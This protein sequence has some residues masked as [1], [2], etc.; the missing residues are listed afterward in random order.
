MN[1]KKAQ[2]YLFSGSG[3]TFVIAKTICDTLKQN[4][5]STILKPIP[6]EDFNLDDD[7]LLGIAFPTAWFSTYPFVL[8]FIDK[9][10]Q[11]NNREVILISTMTQTHFGMPQAIRKILVKKGYKPIGCCT[12]RMPSNYDI[13]NNHDARKNQLI[14][15]KSICIAENFAKDLIKGKTSWQSS[16]APLSGFFHSFTK[17]N[18]PWQIFKKLFGLTINKEKCIKCG[19]CQKICPSDAIKKE[20]TNFVI[21]D[22]CVSCQHCASFCPANAINIKDEQIHYKAMEYKDYLNSFNKKSSQ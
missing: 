20:N 13:K 1:S 11:A 14:V 9:L 5:I 8:N 16:F 6:S 17:T 12:P 19:Q 3:N 4:N 7:C 22:N 21:S 18:T 2:L 15:D 10:P